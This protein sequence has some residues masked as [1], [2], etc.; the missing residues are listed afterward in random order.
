MQADS[1]ASA[2]AK[3]IRTA[4]HQRRH[5]RSIEVLERVGSGSR[6]PIER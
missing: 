5:V 6:T 2:A 1:L 3:A 4:E